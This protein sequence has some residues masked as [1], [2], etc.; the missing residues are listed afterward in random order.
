MQVGL[1]ARGSSPRSTFPGSNEAQWL[2]RTRLAAYSCGG[3]RGFDPHEGPTAFPWSGRLLG[4]T[5]CVDERIKGGW[6]ST[7]KF[8]AG[9]NKFAKRFKQAFGPWP[10]FN[11]SQPPSQ[12]FIPIKNI[13]M[14][15]T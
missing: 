11:S 5:T 1:L 15:Y 14:S 12:F 3:S 6:N 2:F 9:G 7:V 4:R 10:N 8:A 13:V